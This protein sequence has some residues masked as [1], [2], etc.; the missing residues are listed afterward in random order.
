MERYGGKSPFLFMEG[1]KLAYVHVRQGVA[2][3]DDESVVEVCGE[4]FDAP[5]RPE[6]LFFPAQVNGHAVHRRLLAVGLEQRVS[7]VVDVDVDLPYAVGGQ[8][9]E[10]MLDYGGVRDW[11]HRLGDLAGVWVQKRPHSRRQRQW[12]QFRSSPPPSR[13]ACWGHA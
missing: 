2:R 10:D 9:E 5:S 3:D 1:Y 4:A 8:E 6:E 7:H 12:L 11:G 13:G